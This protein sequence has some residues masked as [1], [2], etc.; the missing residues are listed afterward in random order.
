MSTPPASGKNRRLSA[1][2]AAAGFFCALL[3]ELLHVRTYVWPAADS[4]CSVGQR[5]DCVSVAA[6]SSSVFLGLPWAIWGVVGFSSLW[7]AAVLRSRWLWPLALGAAA[8]SLTL[9]GVELFVIGSVCLLCELVHLL[10]V[11]LAVVAYRERAELA[12]DYT[13]P[14]TLWQVFVLPGSV[15]LAC[16]LF[17]PA[18]WG[19]FNYRNEPPY[20]T[21]VTADGKPWIGSSSPTLTVEEFTDYHCPHCAIGTV[22]SLALLKAHPGLRI[23][24]RQHPRLPCRPDTCESARLAH[25]AA[26]QG[27]FWRAD[28]WLFAHAPARTPYEPAALARDLGLDLGRLSSCQNRQDVLDWARDEEA[29]ARHLHIFE[30]PGY[31]ANGKKL[32]TADLGRFVREQAR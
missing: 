25:C 22:R 14:T 5:F 31:F 6:S 26:E 15:A 24:R 18:Y 29:E 2:L 28:R 27:K 32:R 4:F 3:L 10:A 16:W 20:A 8:V 17:V 30:T 13:K 9:L 11:G 23:V 21:G 19:A 12:A 7:V 1:M